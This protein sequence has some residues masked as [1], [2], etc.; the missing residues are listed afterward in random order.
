MKATEIPKSTED[1]VNSMKY[2]RT[3]GAAATMAVWPCG[4]VAAWLCGCV[5]VW[6]CGCTLCIDA[7][8]SPSF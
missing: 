8:K 6:L 5:A 4:G 7:W 1:L 2:L 3:V